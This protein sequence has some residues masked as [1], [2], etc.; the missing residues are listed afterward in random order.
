MTAEYV[1]L[2]DGA[3]SDKFAYFKALLN[4]GLIEL[5]KNLDDLCSIITIMMKDSVMPCFKRKD[6]LIQELRDKLSVKNLG[7]NKKNEFAELS[8]RLVSKSLNSFFTN[9]Y[10]V[11]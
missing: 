5:R 7:I 4:A 9:K 2:M 1:E 11:F 10:D 3:D 6:N 8:E